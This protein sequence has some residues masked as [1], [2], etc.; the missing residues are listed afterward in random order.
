MTRDQLYTGITKMFNEQPLLK[1]MQKEAPERW[2]KAM[3]IFNAIATIIIDAPAAHKSM[4]LSYV[5]GKEHIVSHMAGEADTI[6]YELG[7]N[8]S[9]DTDWQ[10]YL[11]LEDT[12]A[13]QNR[14]IPLG[15][16]MIEG[17]IK[18][19]LDTIKKAIVNGL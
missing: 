19:I 10:F 3:G 16:D 11:W 9:P 6:N 2:M 15:T 8:K 14:W 18:T 1:K 5:G 17:E 7:L 12:E 4:D 13:D